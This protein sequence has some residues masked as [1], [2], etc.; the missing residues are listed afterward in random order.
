[1]IKL[2]VCYDCKKEAELLSIS[3]KGNSVA[4]CK[5]CFKIEKEKAESTKKGGR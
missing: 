2:P 1:M 4:L 5:D 3:R